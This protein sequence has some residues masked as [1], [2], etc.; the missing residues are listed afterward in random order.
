MI[1]LKHLEKL[2]IMKKAKRGS[3]SQF[4]LREKLNIKRK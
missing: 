1:F 2:S 4:Y 3:R